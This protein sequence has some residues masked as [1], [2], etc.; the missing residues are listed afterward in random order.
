MPRAPRKGAAPPPPPPPP[1]GVEVAADLPLPRATVFPL[2]VDELREA[3]ARGGL[4]F[5]PG[6]KGTVT[7]GEVAVGKVETWAPP[8]RFRLSWHPAPWKAKEVT[9]V[10]LRCTTVPGGTHVALQHRGGGGLFET[11]EEAAGWV[12]SAVL[13]PFLRAAAPAALGDW[14]TDR[15]ARRPFGSRSRAVYTDPTFHRP[16]FALLLEVLELGP[17]DRLLEVGCGGGAFLQEALKSG[18]RATAVDHSPEMVRIARENNRAAVD[19]GRL[20]VVESAADRLPV[21]DDTF[22]TAVSTGVLGF[23][24]HP[25]ET[26][27]EVHRALVTGG[28]FAVFT[29]TRELVGTPACPE[30]IA[31]RLRFYEDAEL[32]D[33]ARAAGFRDAEVRHPDLSRYA[34]AAGLPKDAVEMFRGPFLRA[35][36]LLVGHKA[37]L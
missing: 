5:V 1:L 4:T 22:T 2:L 25:L 23:L 15:F 18:C 37:R 3:L 27:R 32:E 11:P 17:R 20:E 21:P 26:F 33:L 9:E 24:P 36:Q 13:A 34:E 14:V 35:S 29:G 31:S 28:R 19:E 30:P 10:E 7:E 6:A 12:A 8:E 16:N